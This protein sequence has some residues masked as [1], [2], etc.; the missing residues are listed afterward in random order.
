LFDYNTKIKV[1]ILILLNIAGI[2]LA[3]NFK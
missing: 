1:I 2:E 3:P